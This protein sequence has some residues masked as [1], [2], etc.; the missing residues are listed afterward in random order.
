M[1]RLR[2]LL[3]GFLLFLQIPVACTKKP[4]EI[5]LDNLVGQPP[6]LHVLEHGFERKLTLSSASR[7]YILNFPD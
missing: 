1:Y 6:P 4:A 2:F 3:P 7:S 5:N